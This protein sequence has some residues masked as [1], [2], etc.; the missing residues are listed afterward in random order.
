MRIRYPAS[1]QKLLLIGFALA[2]LP[3]LIAVADA[4]FSLERLTQRSERAIAYA[5][6]IT[7]ESRVLGEQLSALER[8]ARQQL[9]FGE[10]GVLD[11]YAA[12]RAILTTS[13]THL[14]QAP[15]DA[16]TSERL[17]FISEREAA[18]WSAL[19]QADIGAEGTRTIIA[20]FAKMSEAATALRSNAD[21]RIELNIEALKLQAAEARKQLLHRLL[22][23]IPVGAILLAG[24]IFLIRRPIRQLGEGIRDLGEGLLEERIIV[25]G[26]QDLE[27]LGRELDWLRLRLHEVDEQKMRFLR[28]MSHEL[29]TP[30]TALHEGA[31]LLSEQ[32]PGQ[33]TPE[34]REI[35]DILRGNA[36]RLRVLIESLLDYKGIRFQPMV[37]RREPVVLAGL[38][39]QL[40]EDQKLALAACK[41]SLMADD[42]GYLL[43]ADAEKL[44][45][46]LDNLLSNALKYAPESSIIELVARQ[47]EDDTVL[48]V[49][50]LGPGI[51][52]ENA[53]QLFEPFVQG[54]P[55]REPSSIKGSGL[56]LSI[57]RELVSA[58]GGTVAILG[59]H[60]HGTR[61][62]VT[63]PDSVARTM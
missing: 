52:P 7:R 51:P 22:G 49:A 20:D 9:I 4:Y 15:Q 59:N 38:F 30:L 60:P 26:P 23:M 37:L 39:A 16:Q 33:L 12:R 48:E 58:H 17:A 10:E 56:G 21:S 63:L 29:K 6:D 54:S 45:V 24:M 44:R 19:Q 31:Q 14:R 28:H 32:V 1:F 46:V 41:L 2:A 35:V 3:L 57:V 8:L 62:R 25:R 40:A 42:G 53:E 27:Q 34:Q 47:H 55:P 11:A 36:A 5:V 43:L 18:V 50:D 61:I 13:L